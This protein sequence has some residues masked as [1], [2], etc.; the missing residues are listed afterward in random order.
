MEQR[1]VC[2]NCEFEIEVAQALSAQISDKIRLDLE[3]EFQQKTKQID[4]QRQILAQ[5][6]NKLAED[7]REFEARLKLALEQ[8]KQHLTKEAR[9]Q[10]EQSF[11]LELKDKQAQLEE[12]RDRLKKTEQAELE[13]RKAT[14]E[15]EEQKQQLELQVERRV[16]K[17]AEQIRQAAQKQTSEEYELK[18]AD[19]DRKNSEL[20]KQLDA[21]RRKAEEGSQKAQGQVMELKLEQLLREAFPQDSIEPVPAGVQGADLIQRVFDGV[22][23]GVILWEIKR[24]KH[25]KDAWLAK[26][27]DDQRTIKAELCAIVSEALPKNVDTFALI[28]QVWVTGRSCMLG[29]ATSLRLALI[30]I[31]RSKRAQQGQSS[32]MVLLYD[33]LAGPDFRNRVEGIMEAFNTLDDDLD[34]E[35]RRIQ[36][37]WAKREKQLERA[38]ANTAGLYG[39]LQGII[40]ST[41]AQIESL[42]QKVI[43]TN[44]AHG[45]NDDPRATVQNDTAA[46]KSTTDKPNDSMPLAD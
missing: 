20:L 27:R 44:E 21:A 19:R 17:Q 24:T 14:R 22:E 42:D 9:K 41:L 7:Q 28:D 11:A 16:S 45:N 13:L 32:K 6:T 5:E 8:Q 31:T 36:V 4:H 30:G 40:G 25:W 12:V 29:L 26:L 35:K 23:C 43:E 15:L 38:K 1:I 18:L 3:A 39:D 33:Y 34:A 37:L 10:A 46:S 2:P